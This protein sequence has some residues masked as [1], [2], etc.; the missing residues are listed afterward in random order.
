MAAA[1]Q[2]TQSLAGHRRRSR[3]FNENTLTAALFLL[4]S[5]IALALFIVWP[6]VD[7]FRLSLYEWNGV[8]PVKTWLGAANWTRLVQDGVFW[9]AVRNNFVIVVLSI[10]VQLPVGM[11]LAVLL[12]AGGRRFRIF[13]VLYFLPMLMSTVAIGIL[14]KYLYDPYFGLINTT[15]EAIGLD[16]LTQQWLSD[17]NIALYSV[18]AVICWQFIPFY[19]LLFLAALGGIPA[20]L[21][22]AA[23]IDGATE[24]KYFWRI[25]LPLM[26]GTI[27][28][29]A[30]LS[31][32]G[33]LKYFDLIWV[34]TGGGPVN[35]TELMATYM[36]KRTFQSFEMGYGATI[37]SALFIIVMVLAGTFFFGAQ[38]REEV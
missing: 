12:D 18:I 2:S 38:R 5:L 1:T 11:A 20:E 15:L 6:I 3:I 7:S 30:T 32:I 14:F 21:R 23:L 4:P 37:A 22:E 9:R 34:M 29:A 24:N 19:M 35:A 27:V 36:V 10:L 31:L 25:A 8:D 17:P 13:K 16:A 33:S 26:R 28:T